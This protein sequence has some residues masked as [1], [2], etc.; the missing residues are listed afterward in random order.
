MQWFSASLCL[1][2]LSTFKFA[3]QPLTRLRMQARLP[4]ELAASLDD[5]AAEFEAEL[6]RWQAKPETP[7]PVFPAAAL[8][9]IIQA[10]LQ[11]F[12]QAPRATVQQH[13]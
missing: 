7:E 1:R 8:L 3:E 12:S 10:A 6:A 13:K 2:P 9:G 5:A 4:A 11:V